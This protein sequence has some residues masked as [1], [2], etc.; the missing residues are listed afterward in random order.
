MA[1]QLEG[2]PVTELPPLTWAE[3]G[4]ALCWAEEVAD[5]DDVQSPTWLVIRRLQQI[6]GRGFSEWDRS[7][8]K[9]L[10]LTVL[11]CAAQVTDKLALAALREAYSASDENRIRILAGSIAARLYCEYQVKGYGVLERI[12]TVTVLRE[13]SR[14]NH[15]RPLPYRLYASVIGIQRQSL[16]DGGWKAIINRSEQIM[17]QLVERAEIDLT[18]RLRGIG[19]M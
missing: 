19:V 1:E 13:R 3:A 14:R 9:D 4:R 6:P 15:R 17:C 5:L 7:D 10:A 18:E 16:A 2:L 12:A 11:S 8:F